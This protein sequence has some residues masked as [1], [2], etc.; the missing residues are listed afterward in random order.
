MTDMEMIT[1]VGSGPSS[2]MLSALLC[3]YIPTEKVDR[4]SREHWPSKIV[5]KKPKVKFTKVE[6][7]YKVRILGNAL[8]G[9]WREGDDTETISYGW[10][11]EIPQFP[12]IKY[13]RIANKMVEDYEFYRPTRSL[14][15]QYYKYCAA[16][17]DIEFTECTVSSVVRNKMFSIN[18]DV[19]VFSADK[20]VFATGKYTMPRKLSF[21]SDY[22][23][24][25]KIPNAK[26]KR[27]LVI[28]SGF[29]AADTVLQYIRWDVQVFHIF[30]AFP[31]HKKLFQS[32]KHC[33]NITYKQSPLAFCHSSSYPQ[34]SVLFN[35][36]KNGKLEISD[37]SSVSDVYIPLPGFTAAS[38]SR[39]VDGYGNNYDIEFDY[40]HALI[41]YYTQGWS[42][43]DNVISPNKSK[44][45]P[46]E[47]INN[48]YTC[49]SSEST[50]L[51]CDCL[52]TCYATYK[53]ITK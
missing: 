44:Y 34:Y 30:Y 12:F 18:T 21:S 36:M 49:G 8:G 42:I 50:T 11:L 17:L 40:Y 3:G 51:I 5:L 37:L 13:L 45:Q 26:I 31:E 39:L 9:M 27:V 4:L 38:K 32:S 46:F 25:T 20:V 48:V 53:D 22:T 7:K 23:I 15:A 33:P 41:G 47:Q 35:A 52:D 6:S 28:G 14:V 1:I 43:C 24:P 29:S 16:K 19:G 2:I 10:Q